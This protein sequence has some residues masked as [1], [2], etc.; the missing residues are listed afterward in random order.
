MNINKIIIYSLFLHIISCVTGDTNNAQI[1]YNLVAK[2]I[3][4]IIRLHDEKKYDEISDKYCKSNIIIRGS[5]DQDGIMNVSNIS[6][7]SY[8]IKKL[9]DSEFIINNN[10]LSDYKT[11]ASAKK[12]NFDIIDHKKIRWNDIIFE[13]DKNSH[14][15]V[16]SGFYLASSQLG[17]ND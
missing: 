12:M 6:D 9:L 8:Y 13:Y 14:I 5:L 17:R 2:S 15:Y 16:I 11:L 7:K 1:R 3:K 4:E 10:Q